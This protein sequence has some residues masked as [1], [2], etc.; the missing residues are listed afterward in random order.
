MNLI[1]PIIE[2]LMFKYKVNLAFYGTYLIRYYFLMM[3]NA[4]FAA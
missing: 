4:L 1:Q 3:W 2:P